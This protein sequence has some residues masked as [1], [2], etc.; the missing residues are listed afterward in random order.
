MTGREAAKKIQAIADELDGVASVRDQ[1]ALREL[2]HESSRAR[3]EETLLALVSEAK[4][5]QQFWEKRT[6]S[7]VELEPLRRWDK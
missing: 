1:Q 5:I 7:V 2:V 4:T 3:D 6:E